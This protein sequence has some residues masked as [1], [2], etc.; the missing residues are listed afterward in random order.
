MIFHKG[1][2]RYSLPNKPALDFLRAILAQVVTYFP[3]APQL[4]RGLCQ[5]PSLPQSSIRGLKKIIGSKTWPR[6]IKTSAGEPIKM[7]GIISP[8]WQEKAEMQPLIC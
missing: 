5:D 1:R 4:K 3:W 7:S 2:D 8:K 6:R